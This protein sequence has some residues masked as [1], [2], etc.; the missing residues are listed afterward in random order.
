MELPVDKIILPKSWSIQPLK[1]VAELSRGVSW[2]KIDESNEDGTLVVSI[3]NIKDGRIEYESKFNHYLKIE[4]PES[5]KLKLGDILCVGSSGS[6]HNVGRNSMITYLPKPNIAFASFTFVCRAIKEKIDN[7]F[8]YF[9]LNSDLVPFHYYTKRAADGKFNFQLREF[10]STMRIPLPPLPEQRK[11]AYVLSTVQKAIEQQDKLIRTTTELKKALMQKLFTEGTKGEKLKQTE[12]GWVP[13][14]WEVQPFENTGEVVYGIQAAVASNLKPIGHKILTNKNITLDGK[15][16]LDK[17]NYIVLTSKRHFDAILKKGDLL[18]NWR[19]G[20]K[21]HVGKTAIFELEDGEYVHSSFILR[22]RVNKNHNAKFLFYY[23]NYLREI[24]YY[25]KVQTFSI[26]AK[27]NKSAI[28]AMP[29]AL[30][31]KDVQDLI[32]DTIEAVDNKLDNIKINHKLKTALFKTL[33][34]ELMTGHRRVH[35]I[36][37][38]NECHKV[39][40]KKEEMLLAEEPNIK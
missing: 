26:N 27:F 18:F 2:R 29:I 9:L 13:E 25:Q 4:I 23:L 3:P 38:E 35:E 22:I 7:Y 28:N 17:L 10:E 32:A 8:L 39:R 21:E 1:V 11:I 36:D 33:L 31:K 34:H 37:F 20:S 16:V 6:I 19:S 40:S 15:I 14:S 24:G 5:K 12:I 30:P